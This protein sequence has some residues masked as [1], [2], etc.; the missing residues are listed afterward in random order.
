MAAPPYAAPLA[1]GR[2][3][4]TLLDVTFFSVSLLPI[5][6]G[7][8][9]HDY[10]PRVVNQLLDFVYRYSADILQDAEVRRP[11]CP[12]VLTRDRDPRRLPAAGR[13]PGVLLNWPAAQ[14]YAEHAGNAPGAVELA[15]VETAIELNAATSFVSAPGPDVRPRHRSPRQSQFYRSSRLPV[16][17]SHGSAVGGA[18]QLRWCRLRA[19]LHVMASQVLQE[20][21]DTLNKVPLPPL[22]KQHGLHLPGEESCLT[23]PNY[24]ATPPPSPQLCKE[25]FQGD[26]R[27]VWDGMVVLDVPAASGFLCDQ[28]KLS[29]LPSPDDACLLVDCVTAALLIGRV[30][31]MAPSRHRRD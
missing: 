1:A 24:Q 30:P 7:Q 19:P 28:W 16:G 17:L 13:G 8:G 18:P 4:Y 27:E 31:A 21:A 22:T 25:R 3:A 11:A 20:L 12:P 2:V 10:E 26:A 29:A 5:A 15:D 23:N 9:V 6:G 14:V